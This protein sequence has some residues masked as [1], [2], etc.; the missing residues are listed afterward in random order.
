MWQPVEVGGMVQYIIGPHQLLL[1]RPLTSYHLE[2]NVLFPLTGTS[3]LAW[4]R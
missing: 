2:L 1:A 4:R 3:T